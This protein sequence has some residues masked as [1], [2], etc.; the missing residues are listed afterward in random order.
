MPSHERIFLHGNYQPITV[1]VARTK[2]EH[3]VGA[4]EGFDADGILFEYPYPSAAPFWMKNTETPITLAWYTKAGVCLGVVEMQPYDETPVYPPAKYS[5]VLEV[6]SGTLQL[7][8]NLRLSHVRRYLE[9]LPT[10]E[11]ED[12]EDEDDPQ[13]VPSGDGNVAVDHEEPGSGHNGTEP[14]V[15]DEEERPAREIVGGEGSFA[16]PPTPPLRQE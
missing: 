1:R 15:D 2:S 3:Q 6:P 8:S 11:W 10:D 12:Q 4:S 5:Y 16:V 13:R 7:G 14:V 9:S